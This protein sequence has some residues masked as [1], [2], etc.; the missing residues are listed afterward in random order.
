MRE[1]TVTDPLTP[2]VC[3]TRQTYQTHGSR[4][5]LKTMMHQWIR[6][7]SVCGFVVVKLLN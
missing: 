4:S 2:Q 1:A 7:D 5:T 3:V 6:K